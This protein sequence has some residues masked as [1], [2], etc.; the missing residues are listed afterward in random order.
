MERRPLCGDASG[1][2]RNLDGFK[3]R[4]IACIEATWGFHVAR[5]IHIYL[6]AANRLWDT[7]GTL[8]GYDT[9]LFLVISGHPY[10]ISPNRRLPVEMFGAPLECAGPVSHPPG[11]WSSL[12]R[13]LARN[14]V[15]GDR[16]RN[17]PPSNH[18]FLERDFWIAAIRRILRTY[19]YA[20]I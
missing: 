8:L 15:L 18:H 5:I 13:Q 3:E 4:Q 12:P 9:A 7:E 6:Y 10:R 11:R 14:G 1:R 17:R 2:F 19:K 20:M 16:S